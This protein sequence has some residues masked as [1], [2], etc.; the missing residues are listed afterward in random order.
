M[1]TLLLPLLAALSFPARAFTASPSPTLD[2]LTVEARRDPASADTPE[3]ASVQAGQSFTG[4]ESDPSAAAPVKQDPRGGGSYIM[5]G[6]SPIKGINIYTPKED[7][8]GSGTTEKPK[9]KPLVSRKMMLGSA[10]LGA[11]AVV[12]G[13]LLGGLFGGLLLVLGGALLG[14]AAVMW[15]VNRKTGGK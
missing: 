14:A 4:Q 12:G 11:G 1:A 13:A 7:P 3:D 10:G 8:N 5:V 9:P 15:F 6:R 2:A